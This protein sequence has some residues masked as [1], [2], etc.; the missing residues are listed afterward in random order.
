MRERCRVASQTVHSDETARRIQI[1][2]VTTF[3]NQIQRHETIAVQEHRVLASFV[4]GWRYVCLPRVPF[5]ARMVPPATRI[6]QRAVVATAR[7][8]PP[9]TRIRQRAVA[10]TAQ[11]VPP[12]A[13]VRQRVVTATTLASGPP[14]GTPCVRGL[15]EENWAATDAGRQ[16]ENMG[17]SELSSPCP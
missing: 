13:R 3:H 16:Q 14:R 4:Y 11:I 6:R 7:M 5:T 1:Q 17:D 8:V 9:P 15:L 2:R 10:A 12:T